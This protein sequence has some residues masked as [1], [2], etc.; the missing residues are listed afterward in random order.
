[1]LLPEIAVTNHAIRPLGRRKSYPQR[2]RSH[3]TSKTGQPT[4]H[5]RLQILE[6]L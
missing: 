3:P 4:L 5:L 1:M 2:R 6:C